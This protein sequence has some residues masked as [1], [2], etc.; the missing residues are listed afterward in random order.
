MY[1]DISDPKFLR[2]LNHGDSRLIVKKVANSAR[3]ILSVSFKGRNIPVLSK[4]IHCFQV[5]ILVWIYSAMN[6]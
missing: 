2:T 3:T 4:F 6:H 5:T 1:T